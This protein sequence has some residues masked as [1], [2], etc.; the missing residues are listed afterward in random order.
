M[1]RNYVAFTLPSST[2]LLSLHPLPLLSTLV[3]QSLS[4]SIFYLQIL[5]LSSSCQLVSDLTIDS[6]YSISFIHSSSL[7]FSSPMF[8]PFLRFLSLCSVSRCDG[9]C[10]VIYDALPLRVAT[11]LRSIFAH[12]HPFPSYHIE[13]LSFLM[14]LLP[15]I[16]P[17]HPTSVVRVSDAGTCG[18]CINL[19]R[20][21]SPLLSLHE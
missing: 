5:P 1:L 19:V 14:L 18:G 21:F 12:L 17:F 11:P 4:C 9:S 3:F 2:P 15:F 20:F 13:L 10:D 8:P 7:L 6:Y 16:H